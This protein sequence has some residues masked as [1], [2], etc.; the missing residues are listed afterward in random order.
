LDGFV[1][2]SEEKELIEFIKETIGNLETKYSQIYLL[3]N[4][5]VYKIF[6]FKQG[7]G[8]QPD[9]ILFLEG[10]S[11]FYYQI[12]IE[13]KGNQFKD[14]DKT[15]EASQEGWKEEFL[16]E[17]SEKYGDSNIIKAESKE[18]KLIGLPFYNTSNKQNFE[19][20][21]NSTLLN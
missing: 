12:F 7:R 4:E 2:T 21:F 14:K 13:P 15:F 8:F 16:K 10:K 11:N 9:F 6:D 1:G 19:D 18:Y 20:K 17:I 5:E 3:K